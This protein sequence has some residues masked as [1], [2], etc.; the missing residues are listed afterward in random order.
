[1]A[2]ERRVSIDELEQILSKEE[3]VAVEILP[4]G[5]IRAKDSA[6][7]SER[8]YRKP[9]TMREDLGGEYATDGHR[10]RT[11]HGAPTW[12]DAVSAPL[13]LG[14][15]MFAEFDLWTA[16]AAVQIL[17]NG[18]ICAEFSASRQ[19]GVVRKPLTMREELG[20]EYATDHARLRADF[21]AVSA[22]FDAVEL[23]TRPD[24]TMFAKFAL[25]TTPG[26]TYVG[27]VELAG[28][29]LTMP[30]VT[31]TAPDI[32]AG[33]PHRYTSGCICYM[34]PSFWNPGKHDL[35]FVMAHAA[36]WLNKYEVWRRKR[37]WPGAELA[38]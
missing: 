5:E 13:G 15:A 20:G 28:Y 22:Q 11:D 24:H 19:M 31:I 29:P 16:D 27:S 35:V 7:A 12:L 10:L 21:A 32:D 33:S 30:T 3:D 23:R 26:N 36:K 6:S 25:R 38:H 1:M 34:H 8:N 2:S 4:N 17:P 9:L 37:Y 18:V 14:D